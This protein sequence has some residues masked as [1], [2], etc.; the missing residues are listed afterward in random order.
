M[1]KK[2]TQRQKM[3]VAR[4]T[5]ESIIKGRAWHKRWL[6]KKRRAKR[7]QRGREAMLPVSN[8]FGLPTWLLLAGGAAAVWYFF[9][10]NKV[11]ASRTIDAGPQP[12]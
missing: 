10:R 4:Y 6:A 8:P 5:P 2:M 7:R 9:L 11:P 12:G 1:A 3:A